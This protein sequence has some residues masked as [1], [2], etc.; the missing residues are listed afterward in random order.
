MANELRVTIG[1]EYQRGHSAERF[2]LPIKLIGYPRKANDGRQY[3]ETVFVASG[4]DQ[5]SAG[6]DAG[7]ISVTGVSD[8]YLDTYNNK[9]ITTNGWLFMQNLESPSGSYVEYGPRVKF[10]SCDGGIEQYG[11]DGSSTF[12]YTGITQ[13]SYTTILFGRIEPG[14]SAAMRISPSGVTVGLRAGSGLS[15]VATTGTPNVNLKYIMFND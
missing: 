2:G 3:R 12:S 9:K 8:F 13:N 4:V 5:V 11:A 14:E 10:V 6:L 1:A 7:V 15:D